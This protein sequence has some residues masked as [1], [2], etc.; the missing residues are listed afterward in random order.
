MLSKLNDIPKFLRILTGVS[1]L[2]NVLV[3]VI[4]W[5]PLNSEVFFAIYAL[6][7]SFGPLVSAVTSLL[8]F[9]YGLYSLFRKRWVLSLLLLLLSILVIVSLVGMFKFVPVPTV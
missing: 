6:L 8:N 3:M 9:S 7:F 4:Y 5:S 1:I 2:V